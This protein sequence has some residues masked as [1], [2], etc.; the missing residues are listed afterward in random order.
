[1]EEDTL[2]G[3]RHF[4]EISDYIEAIDLYID[5]ESDLGIFCERLLDSIRSDYGRSV[6]LPLWMVEQSNPQN[7]HMFDSTLL[8]QEKAKTLTS[9]TNSLAIARF[10]E[11]TDL[12]IPL[13]PDSLTV[14]DVLDDIQTPFGIATAYS[15]RTADP[16]ISTKEWIDSCSARKTFPICG[17]ESLCFPSSPEHGQPDIDSFFLT[18]NG[19]TR[20]R[21]SIPINPMMHRRSPVVPSSANTNIAFTNFTV[22]RGWND[23]SKLELFCYTKC[24]KRPY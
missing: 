18:E 19:G 12:L 6:S 3:L 5:L 7:S 24:R 22:F 1:M 11:Y 4:A 15:F 2:E 8:A 16:K 13:T 9:L 23:E 10:S 21:H 20:Q 17:F 14:T